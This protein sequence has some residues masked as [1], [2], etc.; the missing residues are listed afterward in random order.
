MCVFDR[1]HGSYRCT[2]T[3]LVRRQSWY[4]TKRIGEV[5]DCDPPKAD[6]FRRT[7]PFSYHGFD[8]L[9]RPLYIEKTGRVSPDFVLNYFRYS[10]RVESQS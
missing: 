5:T 7:V 8:K 9:G 2:F 6:Y 4:L 1:S 3:L 10:V